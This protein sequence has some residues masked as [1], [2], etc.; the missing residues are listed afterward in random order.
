MNDPRKI[1]ILGAT[2]TVGRGI[3]RVMVAAGW[4]VTAV[5]RDPGKLE[6]LAQA[7]PGVARFAGSVAT[8]ADAEELAQVLGA[9]SG[10]FDAIVAAFNL[11]L[12]SMKLLEC[13]AEELLA[14]LQ[15]NLVS[16]LCAA[17]A[18]LPLLVPGGRYVG[19]GGGMADFTFPGVGPVSICQAGQRNMF[20]FLAMEG[21]ERGVSVVE[22]MLY[23]HIV[24]P[25]DEDTASPR[26]VRADEAGMHVRAVIERPEEFAGPILALKSRKQVGQPQR[27]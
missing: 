23:S 9:S 14:V 20:R 13:T 24:D 15:G 27:D 11:P 8:D 26:D 19:I 22:L 10:S 3:S 17:R 16:H 6:A 4:S 2:G 21:E 7:L 25:A 1:L 18:C 5:A 12:A